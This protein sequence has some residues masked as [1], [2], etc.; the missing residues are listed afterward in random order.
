M[1]K[2]VAGDDVVSENGS[3]LLDVLGDEEAA[4]LAEG[5][6]GRREGGERADEFLVPGAGGAGPAAG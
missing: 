2:D 4:T 5:H 6:V 3:E 1:P